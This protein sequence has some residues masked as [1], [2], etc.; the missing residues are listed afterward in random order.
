ME[1]IN[2]KGL[3]ST[4]TIVLIVYLTRKVRRSVT[5]DL[6][7]NLEIEKSLKSGE[8]I[9]D[10]HP[11]RTYYTYLRYLFYLSLTGFGVLKIYYVFSSDQSLL[12][13][14]FVGFATILLLLLLVVK[15]PSCKSS[16]FLQEM[17]TFTM[18]KP[19]ACIRCGHPSQLPKEMKKHVAIRPAFKWAIFIFAVLPFILIFGY[20]ALQKIL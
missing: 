14:P 19:T 4:L 17:N 10:N 11:M 2:I 7:K 13:L 8:S 16:V 1:Q 15:C 12:Y 9:W 18:E 5:K 3:F 6:I 20:M